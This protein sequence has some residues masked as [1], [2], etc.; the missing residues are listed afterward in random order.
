MQKAIFPMKV[1]RVTQ[2]YGSGTH[3]GT[4]ALDLAGKDA[5]IDQAYAPFDCRV[6]KIW[7][8]G[9]T[10]W[11][12]SLYKVLYSDGR[13]DYA[14]V[15]MTHDNYVSD[16][17]VGGVYKQGRKIYDEGTAGRA[18]GNHIHMEVG[19]GK[20]SGSG[21]FLNTYNIW[22]I[23]NPYPL[24]RLFWLKKDAIVKSGGGYKWKR[25]TSKVLPHAIVSSKLGANVR[26]KPTTAAGKI[27]KV[28][29]YKYLFTMKR[30]VTGQR[31]RVGARWTNKWIET[32]KNRYVST[33]VAKKK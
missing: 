19:R 3:S 5:G 32:G 18:T 21:W 2:G 8:N 10:V 27:D 26:T 6:K 28:I 9:H 12:E 13:K 17:R 14:T 16:L 15:S 1:V 33:L 29:P 20:F 24:H 11:F 4:F 25:V 31:H 23:N 22:T 30:I 7:N